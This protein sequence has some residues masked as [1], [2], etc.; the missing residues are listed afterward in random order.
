MK[1]KDFRKKREERLAKT[2]NVKHLLWRPSI[3]WHLK[4]LAIIFVCLFGV[5]FLLNTLL[6]P[7]MRKVPSDITPWLEKVETNK[8]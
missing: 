3:K 5:F 6:K 4:V 1:F 2:G 8:N 7:Y